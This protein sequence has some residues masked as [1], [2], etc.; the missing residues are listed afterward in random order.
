MKASCRYLPFIL[1]L[2]I[3]LGVGQDA[4][5]VSDT[6]AVLPSLS[7]EQVVDR[8]VQRNLERARLLGAYQG[9]RIYKLEYRGFPGTRSAEMMVDVEYR[10]PGTKKFTIRSEKGSKLIIDRVFKR[11]LESEKEA[12]TTENQSRV[13]LNPTNYRFALVG[14]ENGPNGPAFVLSADP[15]TDNKLLFRGRVWVDAQDFAVV[16]VEATP[17]KN[18]SFW[19]KETKIQQVYARV[20]EFWLPLSNSS[21]SVIRLGGHAE[22]TIQYRDYQIT[23]VNRPKAI[24]EV[25][26]PE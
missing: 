21:S 23:S 11:M 9:T 4:A 15:R 24:S 1:L 16:R 8:L 12:Q 26:G 25:A 18:P 14:Y 5:P 17:A 13:A 3:G 19:M 7:A 6:P 10:S 22:F 20:G 2:L